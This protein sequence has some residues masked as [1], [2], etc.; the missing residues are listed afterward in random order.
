MDVNNLS[1]SNSWKIFLLAFMVITVIGIMQLLDSEQ[2][3]EKV[4]ELTFVDTI[5]EVKEW[6][7]ERTP[8]LKRAEE[9]GLINHYDVEIPIADTGHSLF[10]EKIWYSP[11]AVTIF[12]S[13]DLGKEGYQLRYA[14]DS[15]NTIDRI[16]DLHF[17]F[18]TPSVRDQQP[19][20]ILDQ[21]GLSPGEGVVFVKRFYNQV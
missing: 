2:K 9:L 12:Y 5:E 17:L 11:K 3:I 7:N 20:N 4:E 8:G 1:K 14:R 21:N 19:N 16:P 10:I 18:T 13:I 15:E 6:Q